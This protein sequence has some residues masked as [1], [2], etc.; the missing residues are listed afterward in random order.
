MSEEYIYFHLN[1]CR[2]LTHLLTRKLMRKQ[3][4]VAGSRNRSIETKGSSL[5]LIADR[6]AS[7]YSQRSSM[8]EGLRICIRGLEGFLGILF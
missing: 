8:L 7:R 1:R 4:K 2:K 6:D 5:L 3:R